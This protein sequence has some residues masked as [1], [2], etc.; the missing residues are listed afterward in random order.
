VN[1]SVHAGLDTLLD[2]TVG[3]LDILVIVG[4]LGIVVKLDRRHQPP[5]PSVR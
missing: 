2:L 3:S 1:Q 4:T 5:T